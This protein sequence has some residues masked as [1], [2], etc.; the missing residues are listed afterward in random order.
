VWTLQNHSRVP[1]SIRNTWDDWGLPLDEFTDNGHWP[2]QIYVREA[3]RMVGEVVINQH[4]VDQEAGFEL[5]DSIGMGGYNMDSH[6]VQRV[7][8]NGEVRNEGDVQFPPVNGPYGISYRSIVTREGE[9]DNLLVPVALSATHI[10]YGS[11]RM[12]PVFMALGQSAGAAAVMVGERALAA[13]DVPYSLLRSRLVR[14]GQVLGTEF[15][16]PDPG[17]LLNFGAT[18][19]DNANSPGHALGGVPATTWNLITGDTAA[20]VKNSSGAATE[21]AVNL[22]KSAAGVQEIDW[23]AGGLSTIAAGSQLNTGLYA[24]NASS[25]LF[26]NDGANSQVDLGVRISGLT[27]GVYDAFVAAKNTNTT[28]NESFSIYSLVVD[29][30]S[31]D[32]NYSGVTPQSMIHATDTVWRHGVNTVASTFEIS[33][34]EDLVIV[35]EGVTANQLRGFLNTLELVKLAAPQS[36]DVNGDDRVDLDDFSMIRQNYLANVTLGTNGDANADGLVNHQDFYFWRRVYL[37][38]GGDPAHVNTLHVPEPATAA[39][40]FAVA[41]YLSRLRVH[42]AATP[43][44]TQLAQALFVRVQRLMDVCIRQLPCVAFRKHG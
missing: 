25:A 5:T 17:V 7:V 33:G 3:R 23:D 41:S 37:D 35:V 26:V 34:D 20:G 22:G 16:S 43:F 29:A 10:A 21:I 30:E 38:E 14:A 36:V 1:Q 40:A 13:R 6:N 9:A 18:V 12:E 2:N 15:V 8:I 19:A 4:H 39:Y 27:A 11:I 32:T 42:V 31:G 28:A 44:R 24:G